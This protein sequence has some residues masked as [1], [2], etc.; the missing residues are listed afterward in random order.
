MSASPPKRRDSGHRCMAQNGRRGAVR[1]H[2]LVRTE[3]A[4]ATME[5]D[6]PKDAA[7]S[8]RRLAGVWQG[9]QSWDSRLSVTKGLTAV[10]LCWPSPSGILSASEFLEAEGHPRN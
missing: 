4:E 8:Q 3:K 2:L 10:T 6:I 1:I 9:I 5:Q 7:R